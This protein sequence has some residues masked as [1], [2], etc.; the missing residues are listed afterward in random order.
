M[1]AENAYPARPDDSRP[2][3][4]ARAQAMRPVS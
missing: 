2:D 1:A 4:A 3:D